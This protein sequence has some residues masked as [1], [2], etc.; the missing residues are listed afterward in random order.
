LIFELDIAMRNSYELITKNIP[1]ESFEHSYFIH[2]PSIDVQDE[3]LKDM[4]TYFKSLKEWNKVVIITTLR[5]KLKYND[6]TKRLSRIYS[7]D[8]N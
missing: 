3:T 8:G 2:N 6:T 5:A 1:V 7:K 4:Y